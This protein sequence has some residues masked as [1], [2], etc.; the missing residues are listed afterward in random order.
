VNAWSEI[1]AMWRPALGFL[2]VLKAFT[3]I[4]FP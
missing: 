4:A 1:A 2:C 3:S